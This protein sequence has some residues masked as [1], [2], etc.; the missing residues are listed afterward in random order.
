MYS[1]TLIIEV[2]NYLNANL[3]QK[4]ELDSITQIFHYNKFYLIRLFKKELG[5]TINDYLNQM[6][7]YNSLELI[8]NPNYSCLKVALTY[9]FTSLEYYSETFK[10][11]I[12]I[13]PLKYRAFYLKKDNLT[14]DTKNLVINNVIK[15]NNL[16]EK[17]NYYIRNIKPKSFVKIKKRFI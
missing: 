5:I 4:I 9:G 6:R 13:S 14:D 10:K 12:G 2:L 8:V 7:I 17:S 16:K 11:I 3:Y 15:L 1:N